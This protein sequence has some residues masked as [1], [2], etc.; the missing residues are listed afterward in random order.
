MWILRKGHEHKR[1]FGRI[2]SG[3]RK[4][5]RKSDEVVNMSKVL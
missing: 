3:R 4:R 1:G 2:T 5:K